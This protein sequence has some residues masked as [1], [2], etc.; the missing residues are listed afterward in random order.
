MTALAT[1][2]RCRCVAL[3]DD[4]E[5]IRRSVG[6]L[7]RL[8]GHEVHSFASAEAYLERPCHPDCLIVDVELPG[9]SGF[10]LE[11]QLR[12]PG[13]PIPIVFITACRRVPTTT[14]PGQAPRTVVEKPLDED[15]LLDAIAKATSAQS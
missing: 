10:E 2:V 14:R 13:P 3:V 11:A 4:D 6:R 12:S 8:H 7:L 15:T 1:P 5:L 9:I